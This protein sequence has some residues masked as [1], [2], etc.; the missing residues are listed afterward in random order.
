MAF[1]HTGS[2]ALLGVDGVVVEVQADLEP[3][4]SA[5][6]I[7]GLPDKALSEARDRVRAAVVFP[8]KSICSGSSA[9]R[10]RLAGRSARVGR[11][12]ETAQ[13]EAGGDWIVT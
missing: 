1:A 11:E 4:V 5:F 13:A 9:M 10:P 6:T 12:R 8:V 3:G 2:V 7:V